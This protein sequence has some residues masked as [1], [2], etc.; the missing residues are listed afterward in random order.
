MILKALCDYAEREHLMEDPDFEERKVGCFLRIAPDGSLLSFEPTFELNEKGKA[1]ARVIKAPR[2][3]GRASG[4]F[5]YFLVDKSDYVLGFMDDRKADHNS[6]RCK[7][8]RD[9]FVQRLRLAAEA[10]ADDAMLALMSFYEKYDY[11]TLAQQLPEQHPPGEQYAFIYDP[12]G[13]LPIHERPAIYEYWRKLRG[14]N[15]K[16]KGADW[17]CLITGDPCCPEKTHPKI[18][19]VR[20]AQ[21]SGGAL[22][23]F[24][25][26]AAV[27]Y[28]L[29]Q[30]ENAPIGRFAAESYTTALSQ[31]LSKQSKNSIALN[32]DTVS[33]F[34]THQNR[35]GFE[36]VIGSLLNSA[37]NVELLYQSPQRGRSVWLDDADRFYA[38]TLSGAQGRIMVRDWLES[39]VAEVAQHL[40]QHFDDLAL[41]FPFDASPAPG[42]LSLLRSIVLQGKSE[43]IQPN[44]AANV[45]AAALRGRPYPLTLLTAAIRRSHAEGPAPDWHRAYLRT[46]VIKASLLRAARLQ[47]LNLNPQEVSFAMDPNNTNTACRLGRLFSLLE[48]LQARAIGNPNASIADRFFGAASTNPIT[49]FPRL[50]KLAQHHAAKLEGGGGVWHQRQ[51]AEILEPVNE[52]PTTLDLKDQGLFALGYYH[53]RAEMFRKKTHASNND[54]EIASTEN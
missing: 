54:Q 3:E 49:V 9:L 26:E 30:N 47:T 39:S 37:E 51:I 24:N 16:E 5:A 6:E 1:I 2:G 41:D 40:K 48:I 50:I 20:G 34:W 38:L 44:L 15:L 25:F 12:D 53:Q 22:V 10:T 45:Y 33:C 52:F 35:T 19:G 27:S 32:Y 28:G 42:L 4:N 17:T 14:S 21:S 11:Q 18:K 36:S 8:R 31:L 43:N 29:E 23:S 46:C 7:T 13:A